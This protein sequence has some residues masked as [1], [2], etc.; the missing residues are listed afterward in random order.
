MMLLGHRPQ[1]YVETV[2][3]KPQK[4]VQRWQAVGIIKAAQDIV[5]ASEVTGTIESLVAVSGQ[6]VKQGDVL[7]NIR[8]E[9]ILA[10]LQKDQAILTQ[11]QLY[12]Q[13]LQR[14]FKASSTSQ[15][16][17]SEAV[18]EFQQAQAAV[19][20]DQALLDK[21][22][23]K[24]P[25][26]GQVGIWQVNV[27]QLVQPGDRLV[28]LT[29]LSPVYIDFTLPAKVLST[30]QVGN[31]TTFTTTSYPNR[32]WHAKIVAI[33][34]QLD[35]ATHNVQLRALLDN[36]D[37]K[38]VPG[39]YGQ[40]VVMIPGA[41]K[42]FIPQEAVIYDPKGASVYVLDKKNIVQPRYISLGLHQN[43]AIIVEKGL[44]AGEEVVTAG[45]MKLFPGMPVTVNKRVIQR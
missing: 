32:V 36:T 10:T 25:F 44:A 43:N 42:L 19:K 24:A 30:V 38:L 33:D 45:V 21:Y 12:Y 13:R 27:G 31:E 22:I 2:V 5:L 37:G 28:S 11:K 41:A 14:L 35:A 29:Q 6:T 3:L 8:H 4:T 7:L 17:L 9:D 18:S 40:V 26:S 34:P 39:L 16:S 23:I 15:E 20:S 1:T